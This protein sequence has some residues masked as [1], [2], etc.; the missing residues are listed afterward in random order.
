MCKRRG[1]RLWGA[2]SCR[3]THEGVEASASRECIT[4]IRVVLELRQVKMQPKRFTVHLMHV[5]MNGKKQDGL[6]TKILSTGSSPCRCEHFNVSH[7]EICHRMF[8]G[9]KYRAHL[10]SVSIFVQS[11]TPYPEHSLIVEMRFHLKGAVLLE[12]NPV[13]LSSMHFDSPESFFRRVEITV[14]FL[15]SSN[16][17]VFTIRL[18]QNERVLLE[19]IV[20]HT[21]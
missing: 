18:E 15:I 14:N 5:T 8:L 17:N 9:K 12:N 13:T 4:S 21:F 16:P 19:S 20:S 11:T 1:K 10:L 6:S 2:S 3:E 7:D